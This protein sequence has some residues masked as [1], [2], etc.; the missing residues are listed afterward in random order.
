MGPLFGE[1]TS[2]A[3]SISINFNVLYDDNIDAREEFSC[4]Y[5][6]IIFFSSYGFGHFARVGSVLTTL[7]ISIQHLMVMK[8][9][10]QEKQF[11]HY[12]HVFPWVIAS[13]F[14]I[15]RFFEFKSSP[16][17]LVE[18]E[19]N[20]SIMPLDHYINSLKSLNINFS[21]T[22]I[23]NNENNEYKFHEVY[24]REFRKNP[25]YAQVY[26][27]WSKFLFIELI[28]YLIMIYVAI[29][30]RKKLRKLSVI[31]SGSED[32]GKFSFVYIDYLQVKCCGIFFNI[33]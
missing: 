16:T 14:N 25:I 24:D 21:K 12:L 10:Q 17:I 32:E 18:T 6:I 11:G 20:G 8:F 1:A 5:H 22:D 9:P 30:V 33:S 23:L 15:P 19:R 13:F 2:I 29:L 27:F 7:G 4:I 3:V 26:L 31:S 28:P